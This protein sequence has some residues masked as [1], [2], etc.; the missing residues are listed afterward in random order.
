MLKKSVKC[1]LGESELKC[2]FPKLEIYE[3]KLSALRDNSLQAMLRC[4]Y[5]RITSTLPEPTSESAKPVNFTCMVYDESFSGYFETLNADEKIQVITSLRAV[6]KRSSALDLVFITGAGASAVIKTVKE[7]VEA[8]IPKIEGYR[9]DGPLSLYIDRTG[10]S[11]IFINEK[12]QKT[13][14]LFLGSTR[15]DAIR[16]IHQSAST[17]IRLLPW[18]FKNEPAT[19]DEIDLM[20]SLTYDTEE[21]FLLLMDK[22][23][24]DPE[25]RKMLITAMTADFTSDWYKGRVAA[26]ERKILEAEKVI[27]EKYEEIREL[28][29]TKEH[30]DLLLG[31]VRSRA[32]H[33]ETGDSEFIDYLL[34]N[35]EI[36]LLRKSADKI[37][38]AIVAPMENYDPDKF[39][40]LI[41]GSDGR[42]Y[43]YRHSPYTYAQSKALLNAIW[44]EDKEYTLMNYAAYSINKQAVVDVYQMNDDEFSRFTNC[45]PNP[46]IVRLNCLGDYRDMLS[47]AEENLDFVGALMVCAQSARSINMSENITVEKL[48]RDLWETTEAVLRDAQG[49]PC[50]VKQAVE[51]LKERGVQ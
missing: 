26:L 49:N 51:K 11:A 9:Y 32:N 22:K 47:Q 19:K 43:I 41:K 23:Y 48:M 40:R 46:H 45:I 5:S 2:C 13:I 33:G 27:D 7:C 25:T 8:Q 30:D 38:F 15:D 29:R 10:R 42:D 6:E 4:I 12:L 17:L 3:N 39:E 37:V 24:K 1:A 28:R 31:A 34:I 36:T 44:G 20:K 21:Q 16:K 18:L 35:K 50:T 14:C